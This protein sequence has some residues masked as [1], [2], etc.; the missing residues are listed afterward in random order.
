M[1]NIGGDIIPW[2]QRV[3]LKNIRMAISKL[4]AKK[5]PALSLVLVAI[6]GA[7]AGVIAGSVTV[8]QLSYTG[9]QGTYHNNTGAFTIADNGPLVA[10]NTG[11]AGYVNNTQI[12]GSDQPFNAN[13]I[14][15]GHWVDSISIGTSLTDASSHKITVTIRDGTGTVGTTILTFGS[16]STFIKAPA[17]S[18]AGTVTL[19][20]DLGTSPITTPITAYVTV[21]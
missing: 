1:W 14:T 21:S 19:Y 10:A 18:L 20:F 6:V 8:T 17:S 2:Q 3:I 12:T 4:N 13:A 5:V 15:A 11:S 9:E 7:V 16:S